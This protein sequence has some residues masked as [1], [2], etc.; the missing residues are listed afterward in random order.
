M[1]PKD[2]KEWMQ[3]LTDAGVS[4]EDSRRIRLLRK[5]GEAAEAERLLRKRRCSLME[6]MHACHRKV[7]RIDRLIYDITR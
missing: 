6:E 3:I 5:A 1:D 2:E 4:E 7:D